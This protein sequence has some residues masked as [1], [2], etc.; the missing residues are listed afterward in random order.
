VLQLLGEI[1]VQ[2][3]SPRARSFARNAAPTRGECI[4]YGR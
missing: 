1:A 4:T 3:N 2:K